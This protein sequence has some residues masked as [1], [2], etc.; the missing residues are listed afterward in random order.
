MLDLGVGGGRT[1]LHFAPL[2]KDYVAVD[3]SEKMVAACQS[4]FRE[5]FPKSSFLQV[6][7]CSMP[8]FA[9][10]AFDFA[11]FSYNGLDYVAGHQ[12]QKALREI[13][14]VL[15]RG[16]NFAFS[17]HNLNALRFRLKP[18]F[19][20]H[21]KKLAAQLMWKA[22]FRKHN[23]D[24]RDVWTNDR[25][26]VNDGAVEFRLNTYYLEPETQINDLEEA[27]FSDVRAF[28]LAGGEIL[29]SAE[30]LQENT[31]DWIYYLCSR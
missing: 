12:R 24:I 29:S 6:D 30:S 27:G 26:V 5:S 14:R 7:A 13:G 17:S 3:Y 28:S 21:P 8:M 16:G 15:R 23:R 9:D 18:Q 11:L 22:R 4:R 1:T 10:G 25:A 2:V 19:W 20:K 31:E